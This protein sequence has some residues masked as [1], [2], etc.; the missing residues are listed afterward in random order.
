MLLC[1]INSDMS[2]TPTWHNRGGGLALNDANRKKYASPLAQ[3][4]DGVYE[5]AGFLYPSN[6][7]EQERYMRFSIQKITH[8][9]RD[10][11]APLKDAIA[12]IYLPMPANLGTSYHNSYDNET[13]G[14]IGNLAAA[15]TSKSLGD[16]KNF[17]AKVNTNTAAQNTAL[18]KDMLAGNAAPWAKNFLLGANE[19]SGLRN[20]PFAGEALKGFGLALHETANPHRALLFNG[21]D[22]RTHHFDFQF[23]PK[24]FTESKA[25]RNII[26]AFKSAAAPSMKDSHYFF[27]Y[28]HEFDISFKQ[29][30]FLFKIAPSVLT[31]ISVNYHAQGTPLYFSGTGAAA[32]APVSVSVSLDF[33]EL[34]ITTRAEIDGDHR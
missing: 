7:H 28:P 23:A 16:Y 2:I 1:S 13:L 14:A 8:Y 19:N 25:V 15:A 29:P 9:S 10:K 3:L 17:L 24:N 12:R 32:G 31:A 5:N 18:F 33:M 30:N 26:H 6:L 21:V 4:E 20:L 11:D 22:F 27:E 34:T